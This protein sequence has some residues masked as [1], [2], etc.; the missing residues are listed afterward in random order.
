MYPQYPVVYYPRTDV[1]HNQP[2]TDENYRNDE[3]FIGPFFLP[4]VAGGLAG[5]AVSPFFYGA[6]RPYPY[7]CYGYPCY[8]P[9]GPYGPGPYPY[10]AP[11]RLDETTYNTFTPSSELGFNGDN[12]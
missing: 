6:F 4:F 2:Y 11:Y 7:P 5:L 3:R 9:Y 1:N 8:P 12:V 10:G